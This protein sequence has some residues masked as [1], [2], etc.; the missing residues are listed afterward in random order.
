M[1]GNSASLQQNNIGL[2]I[3]FYEAQAVCKAWYNTETSIKIVVRG[4]AI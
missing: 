2:A 4:Q 1:K 3:G